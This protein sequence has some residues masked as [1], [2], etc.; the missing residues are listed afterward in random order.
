MI[1]R[2]LAAILLL[3][4]AEG[5]AFAQMQRAVAP[6]EPLP[7]AVFARLPETE[8]PRINTDGTAIAAKV[9]VNGEQILAIIPLDEP[10]PRP[11]PVARDGEFDERGDLYTT[12]WRWID[13]DNLLISIAGRIDLDGQSVDATRV[14]S[15][16]RRTR[17][18]TRLG[19][20]GTFVRGDRVLWRST[21]GPPRILLARLAT[22]RGYERL[23]NEE[24][25]EIDVT[26]GRH[27]VVMPP[28]RGVTSWYADG[29][30]RLRLG[31]SFDR[32]SGRLQALY[33]PD[34]NNNH[35]T[36][37]RERMQRYQDAPVPVAFLPGEKA[38]VVSR[39]EGFRA[40]YEMDL[41]TMELGRK[42]FGVEGYDIPEGGGIVMNPEGNAVEG[43]AAIRDRIEYNWFEPRLRDIQQVL[44]ESFGAGRATIVSTDRARQNIVVHVGAPNQAGGYYL[45]QTETGNVRHIGW[46]NTALRDMELNPVRTIRYRTS[47]GQTISAVLTL[48]RLREHRN[49]P[50]ILLP[51]GGP[52]ARDLEDWDI[53]AQPLAELGYAVVQPNFRG[54]SGYGYAWEAMSDGNWG[55]RMQDDLN[56]AVD[57][58]V[59]EGIADRG[60]VCIMGWS[61]GGYAASRAA[62]RDGSRYRCA[63]SGAGVH[64][65][66]EMIRFDRDYLGRYG[67]QYIGSAA[68]RLADISP[69]RFARQ[70]STPILIVHGARDQRV[71]VAQSRSLVDRLRDAG[72][73]EGRD[74][75]YL[76]Q[77]RNTHNLPREEDR[78]EFLEAVQRFL[79]QHNPA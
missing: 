14:I 36:I 13:A 71:P 61:Y 7:I 30:G 27:R 45:Y 6:R 17:R 42:V 40:L 46:R 76:E 62:Q 4:A 65:L 33:S 47:D 63:I 19:W 55:M 35:R 38:L 50:L 16:N 18:T 22:G 53:W 51:H 37:I 60:R 78:L 77:R 34:G 32:E 73:V 49:L 21:S 29:E 25:I 68:S 3:V 23:G 57:H 56:D 41:Q 74:F 26:T 5:S 10:N 44:D 69:A 9:R 48:P 66:P 28:R 20:D 58:L 8:R 64:D 24:V 43:V 15:Y 54:S 12:D 2:W 67:S 39:H 75:V 70:Y 11:M 31:T 59:Q 79:A 72:K 52:W 1:R